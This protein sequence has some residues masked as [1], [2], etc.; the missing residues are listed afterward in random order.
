MAHKDV[1]CKHLPLLVVEVLHKEIV[2]HQVEVQQTIVDVDQ[3]D[4]VLDMIQLED[5]QEADTV[6]VVD[7]LNMQLEVV[8]H[9][10]LD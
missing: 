8:D 4:Q 3:D 1:A 9:S 5:N 2:V 7:N 6:L 10:L